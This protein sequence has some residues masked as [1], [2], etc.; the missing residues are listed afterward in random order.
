MTARP[1]ELV[2]VRSVYGDQHHVR[3]ADLDGKRTQLPLYFKTG[4]SFADSAV[5]QP[6]TT[7][8]RGN[9]DEVLK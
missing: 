1:D 6:Y 3:R 5:R 9:I 7:I 8:H 2:R 4:R